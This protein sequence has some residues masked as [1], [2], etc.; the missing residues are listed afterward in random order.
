[1]KQKKRKNSD[2]TI[3][4]NNAWD[5]CSVF[6]RTRDAYRTLGGQ[7][8]WIEK[9]DGTQKEVLACLCC[10]CNKQYPAFGQGC[11]QAGHF[12]PG[13]RGAV[14]FDERGI[15]FQC[16]NCNTNLKSNPRKY[17]AFMLEKYGQD[18]IDELDMLS[19]EEVSYTEQDFK[20]IEQ[21][22]KTETEKIINRGG[23]W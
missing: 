22:F 10:T 17:H 12:I 11:G 4:K 3:A 14:L 18:L 23:V 15:H 2:R 19:E 6:V 7:T 8:M 20:R 16:Y 1:M 5:A 9:K 13:R 21:Y